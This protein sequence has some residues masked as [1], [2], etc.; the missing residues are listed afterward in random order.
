MGNKENLVDRIFLEMEKRNI[1]GTS[2]F[3][4]FS[5]TTSVAKFFKEKNYKIISNDLLYFSYVLQQAYISNNTIPIFDKININFESNMFEDRLSS[6]LRILDELPPVSGFISKNYTPDYTQNLD[7]PRMYFTTENGDFIDKVRIAIQEWY[8]QNKITKHEYYILIACLIE[9]VPYYA[10]ISGVYGAFHKKW[11]PRA[12]KKMHLKPINILI[13]QH[14]NQVFNS[15]SINLIKTDRNL[16]ADIFYLDPPYNQRQ[17]APNYHLLETI[18]KYD[19]PVIKGVSG[20]REYTDQKSNFCNVN[21]AINELD[22]IVKYGNFRYL[23]MSYNSEG[24]IPK[25]ALLDILST[26]GQMSFVEFDYLRYKSNK[27][28]SA[29]KMI[30]E[31]LF[32]LEKKI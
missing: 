28:K 27:R 9:T 3:D 15:N 29:N 19:N 23:V 20:M 21:T 6:V 16:Q 32:F 17:Y 1:L 7:I 14:E 10:N 26:Y 24:I 2:I 8:E 13:N 25:E 11:D 5:G 18:A 31:Q 4:V 22:D 30:K 12:L